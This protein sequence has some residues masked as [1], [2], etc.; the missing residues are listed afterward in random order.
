[1]DKTHRVHRERKPYLWRAL[2]LGVLISGCATS[3][4]G[5]K[6]QAQLEVEKLE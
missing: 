4:D 6:K 3:P 2:F 1:M 5:E